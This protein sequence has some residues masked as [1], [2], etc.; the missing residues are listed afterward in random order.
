[1]KRVTVKFVPQ[2][3][4]PEQKEHRAT[5]A[6]DLIQTTTNE[7]DFLKITTGDE[8]WVYS[9]VLEMKAQS[10]QWELPGSP[11]L[12][13]VWQS[14]CKIKTMLTVFFDWEGVVHHE[15][16]PPGQT[17]NKEDYLSVLCWSR[18]NMTKTAAVM[19][20]RWL[21]ASSWLC[22]AHASG[23]RQ[24]MQCRVYLWNSK[25]PTA[26]MW[27]CEFWLFLKLKSPW[28]GKRFQTVNESQENTTG[29]LM[30]I[31]T[32][33]F[34]EGFEQWKRHWEN[35]VRSQGAYLEGDWGVIV[36][37]TMFFISCILYFRDRPHRL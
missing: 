37:W 1:M 8:S 10:S 20:N 2:L 31:P 7:P 32:K 16:T 17:V 34:E 33:D 23:L 11:C 15:Y 9:Y 6:N 24:W 3:L 22:A 27:H 28:K 25:S 5:V 21:A 4:L 26:Q 19:G 30:V 29:Q 12:E 35:C 14:H 36:L 18:G 13:K